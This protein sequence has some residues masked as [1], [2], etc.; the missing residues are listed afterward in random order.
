MSRVPPGLRPGGEYDAFVARLAAEDRF[1]GNVLV[2]R[3]GRPVLERSHGMADKTGG[4]PNTADTR[5]DLASITKIFT[6]VAA[7]QLVQQGKAALHETLGTYVDGFPSEIAGTVTVHQLLTHTSGLGGT[8]IAGQD[9]DSVEEMWNLA[10]DGV[11]TAPPQF[12]PGTRF[13]YSN[14]GYL[15]LGAVVAAVG[16]DGTGQAYF[17]YVKRNI[18]DRA[19]MK[20]SGFFTRP[21]ILAA[22][23]FARRYA[24]DRQNGGRHE[25]RPG[26]IGLPNHGAYATLRDL[27]V[28]VEALYD[29]TLLD[30]GH[31][32]LLTGAKTA[33][34][35]SV[36]PDLAR[37][38]MS[39]G[40]GVFHT[41][42]NR[43]TLVGHS[44]SAA[45]VANMLDYFPGS[46]WFSAV[47]SNYD[48]TVE[49]IVNLGRRL[50][51]Q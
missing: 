11:R 35:P 3:D 17:D 31:R 36:K 37:D 19:G 12:T 49:P 29:G 22:D 10:M 20:R 38:V 14:S 30:A 18:F 33:V 34:P 32:A 41:I 7:V 42:L 39:Y 44:G 9:V 1:S 4:R 16:G 21:Q 28:F 15:V 8:G 5:F 50:I 23:D 13:E 25:A 6:A 46:G 27:A 43:R 45:G 24:T 47:V 26:F 48:D 51:T 2:M 40:Y